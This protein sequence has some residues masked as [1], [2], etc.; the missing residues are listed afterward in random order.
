MVFLTTTPQDHSHSIT[1]RDFR[2]FLLFLPRKAS[3]AEIY[4]YYRLKKYL[5]ED[6][7]GVAR[8]TMEGSSCRL[9]VIPAWLIPLG[10]VSL[11]AEDK[12]PDRPP[13]SADEAVHAQP[14]HRQTKQDEQ[15]EADD[16]M[17]ESHTA[18]K[19]LLAGGIAGAGAFVNVVRG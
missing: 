13:K 8:V 10:D 16:T 19:F 14:E 6:G 17:I 18:L 12:P 3:T 7:R 11:S 9:V 5:G 15:E 1:F 4:Q 2:D